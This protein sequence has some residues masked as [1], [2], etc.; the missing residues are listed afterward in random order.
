VSRGIAI[1][2]LATMAVTH[3]ADLADKLGEAPYMAGLFIANIAAGLVLMGLLI[4]RRLERPAIEVGGVIAL[5]TLIG[6]VLSRSVGLPEIEDHVGH[7]LDPAGIASVPAEIALVALALPGLHASPRFLGAFVAVPMAAFLCAAAAAGQTFGG[8]DHADAH[9]HGAGHVHAAYP[10]VAAASAADREVASGLM[11]AAHRDARTLFPT[12]AAARRA[13]FVRYAHRGWRR[14]LV[15][16]LRDRAFEHD[17]RVMDPERPESLV[18]WWPRH[19]AP[20]LLAMM[21]RVPPGSQ[22]ASAGSIPIFHRHA[23]P[24]TGRPGATLMTHVW[25]TNDLRSAFANCLPVDAL[26]RS[27]PD[28]HYVPAP[29]A[30]AHESLPCPR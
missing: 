15:I 22:P 3:F 29:D 7:W 13:G 28:F 23:N 2:A 19:G 14:P 26:Q 9:M 5:L 18:Y 8:H 10:D 4:A 11:L 20:V 12:Y 6:F 30:Q 16:H 25:L 21:F 17:G 24:K 1:A 27:H